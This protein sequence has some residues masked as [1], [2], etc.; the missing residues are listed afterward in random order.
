MGYLII[1]IKLKFLLFECIFSIE[2][3]SGLL[4]IK[5]STKQKIN[6]IN[7][8]LMFICKILN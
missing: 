7:F 6:I 1:Y 3:G 2:S 8:I 5:V 4:S